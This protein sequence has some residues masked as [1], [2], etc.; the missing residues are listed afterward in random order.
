MTPV[1][2][3]VIIQDMIKPKMNIR[4]NIEQLKQKLIEAGINDAD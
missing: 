4:E 3:P 2:I 1:M